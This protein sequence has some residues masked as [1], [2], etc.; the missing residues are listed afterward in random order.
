MA[1]IVTSSFGSLVVWFVVCLSTPEFSSRMGGCRDGRRCCF[2]SKL[3]DVSGQ[4]KWHDWSVSGKSVNKT[5]PSIGSQDD[6]IVIRQ[7]TNTKINIFH[8]N[9]FDIPCCEDQGKIILFADRK[10]QNEQLF[11]RQFPVQRLLYRENGRLRPG[12]RSHSY[13]INLWNNWYWQHW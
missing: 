5:E 13:H 2:F 12:G 8:H 1:L 9:L 7:Q 6:W 4:Q 11:S 10:V 3:L